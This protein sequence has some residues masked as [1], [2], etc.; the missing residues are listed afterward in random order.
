MTKFMQGKAN[1]TIYGLSGRMINCFVQL[2]FEV[3]M[4]RLL[5]VKCF[6][7]LTLTRLVLGYFIPQQHSKFK[8]SQPI[9]ALV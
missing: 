9:Q 4:Y 3:V 1:V 7:V 2:C 5:Y 8:N 6:A